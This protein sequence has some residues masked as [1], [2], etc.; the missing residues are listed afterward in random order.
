MEADRRTQAV[1]A[2]DVELDGAIAE[3]DVFEHRLDARRRRGMRMACTPRC[4]TTLMPSLSVQ[5]SGVNGR[6]A[7]AAPVRAGGCGVAATADAMATATA[8][9]IVAAGNA[10]ETNGDRRLAMAS[11]ARA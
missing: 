6:T 1:R 10:N 3:D 5:R 2:L 7:P 4:S 11:M 8:T 9:A